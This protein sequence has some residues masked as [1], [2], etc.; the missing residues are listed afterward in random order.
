MKHVMSAAIGV[1]ALAATPAAFASIQVSGKVQVGAQSQTITFTSAGSGTYTAAGGGLDGVSWGPLIA[2]TSG[3]ALSSAFFSVAN[4][5][6]S[7]ATAIFSVTES[8]ITGSTYQSM[9]ATGSASATGATSADTIDF[10]SQVTNSAN[11]VIGMEDSGA[12]PLNSTMPYTPSSSVAYNAGGV[13]LSPIS[14]TIDVTNTWTLSVAN[15]V[16]ANFGGVVTNLQT[17]SVV[18]P[19]PASLAIFGLGAVG[20]VV[21][22]RRRAKA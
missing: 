11:S 5:S 15:G 21:G 8:G 1:M 9:Q 14:P 10:S 19:E 13:N 6:G 12:L 2:S 4:N 18:V 17:T 22:L 3:N 16:L 7:V 20:A